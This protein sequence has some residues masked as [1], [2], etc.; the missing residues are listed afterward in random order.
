MPLSALGGG[1]ARTSKDE[2]RCQNIALCLDHPKALLC[3]YDAAMSVSIHKRIL[4]QTIAL[5]LDHFKALLCICIAANNA[6]THCRIL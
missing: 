1:E 3:G 2:L 6:S 4:A 5:C